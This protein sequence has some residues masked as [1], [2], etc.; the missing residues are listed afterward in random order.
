MAKPKKL[1]FW[2]WVLL[3]FGVYFMLASF[4]IF[5]FYFWD[6]AFLNLVYTLVLAQLIRRWIP[7]SKNTERVLRLVAAFMAACYFLLYGNYQIFDFVFGEGAFR[8]FELFLFEGEGLYDNPPYGNFWANLI[9]YTFCDWLMLTFY[10]WVLPPIL[11][12][13]IPISKH[14]TEY[15]GSKEMPPEMRRHLKRMRRLD[16]VKTERDY[17]VIFQSCLPRIIGKFMK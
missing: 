7:I 9:V 3:A 5:L 10:R 1:S 13:E 8:K 2:H 4:F 6:V 16:R 12:G 11:I 15:P 17:N 14:I